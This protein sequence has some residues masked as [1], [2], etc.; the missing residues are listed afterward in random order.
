MR[1]LLV[2]PEGD[3]LPGLQGPLL[4]LPGVELYCAPDGPTAIQHAGFL[5]GVDILLTEV[6]LQGLDGFALRDTLGGSN[7]TLRTIFLTR[8]D[9]GAHAA[10]VRDTPVLRLPVLPEQL[11][12]LMNRP[13]RGR[14]GTPPPLPNRPASAAAKAAPARPALREATPPSAPLPGPADPQTQ[15]TAPSAAAAP[16]SPVSPR[17]EASVAHGAPLE[18]TL[19]AP[20]PTPPPPELKQGL[21]LGPYRLL[22]EDEPTR[23]GQTF[24]AVHSTL[25]RPVTLVLLAPKQAGVPEIREEFLAEAGAKASVQHPA[26]LTVYEACEF[27][28]HLFYTI[29]RVDGLNLLDMAGGRKTLSV[30]VTLIL[31]RTAGEGMQHLRTRGIPHVPLRASAVLLAADGSPRLQNLA[32]GGLRPATSESEDVATLGRC[33]ETVL[34]DDAP[35]ALRSLLGRTAPNHQKRVATWTDFLAGIAQ[36]ETAWKRFASRSDSEPYVEEEPPRKRRKRAPLLWIGALAGVVAAGAAVYW[37]RAKT[38]LVPYQVRVPGGQYLVGSGRRVALES[39]SIDRTEVS[40]R[41]YGLFLEWQRAHPAEAASFDH[42]DQPPRHSHTPPHWKDV[43][44]EVKRHRVEVDDPRWE[45]PVTEVCWWDAFAFARW[46]GRDLPTE[47]EWE[48]AGRGPRGLLFP[49]GDE[50][51]P[52]RSNVKRLPRPGEVPGTQAVD[53]LQDASAFGVV[54]LSGNVSEWTSTLKEDQ[55]AVAKGG[56]FNAPLLTLDAASPLPP[57]TRSPSLGFRTVSRKHSRF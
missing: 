13:A 26:V 43:F 7:P 11:L 52:D 2:D 9:L 42:P 32:L 8:H 40:N 38:P 24:T 14:P 31:A 54:G 57:E 25:G 15:P 16:A 44:P 23:W 4:G 50:P 33:I 41:Q 10:Q 46:A 29:E 56:H 5:G 39:F 53:A 22:R 20:E 49:W 3:L 21:V 35:M 17:S 6:F 1:V 28:G 30:E 27:E 51:D 55:G 18:N 37:T 12:P 34:G 48:A 47:D 36:C 19:E 45:L